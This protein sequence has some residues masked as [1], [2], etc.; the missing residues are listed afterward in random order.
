M[1]KTPQLPPLTGCSPLGLRPVHPA[2]NIGSMTRDA[3][4]R[5]LGEILG[6]TENV[7]SEAPAAPAV[8][9]TVL[10][11]KLILKL[12]DMH[13]DMIDPEAPSCSMADDICGKIRVALPGADRP[14]HYGRIRAQSDREG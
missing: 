8:A 10:E 13:A 9:F 6:E 14:D 12:C 3:R 11:L 5:P 1:A 2:E 7:G 4:A